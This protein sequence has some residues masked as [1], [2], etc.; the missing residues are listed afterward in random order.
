MKNTFLIFTL[1]T[2]LSIVSS[3]NTACSATCNI[4]GKKFYFAFDRINVQSYRIGM[5]KCLRIPATTEIIAVS[6]GSATSMAC[7]NYINQ[8]VPLSVV[9]TNLWL[10]KNEL[11]KNCED[12]YRVG[13]SRGYEYTRGTL[14]NVTCSEVDI[15]RGVYQVKGR[16]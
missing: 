15:A 10:A 8:S 4:Y 11:T 3:A 16:N 6:Q 1:T 14:E 13:D 2:L 5:E 7:F 12:K 9:D